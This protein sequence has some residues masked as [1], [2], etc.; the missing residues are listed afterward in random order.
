MGGGPTE[1]W[2]KDLGH[3][4]RRLAFPASVAHWSLTPPQEKLIKIENRVLPTARYVVFQIAEA[5]VP[6]YLFRT[7]LDRMR[8]LRPAKLS[9]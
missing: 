7:T 9:E 8:R 3:L 4:L 2:I 6:R 5:A 1:Q